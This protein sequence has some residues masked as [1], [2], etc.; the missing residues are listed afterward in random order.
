MEPGAFLLFK[1]ISVPAFAPCPVTTQPALPLGDRKCV[2]PGQAWSYKT[3]CH[4][5]PWFNTSLAQP[6][7][8]YG[9]EGHGHTGKHP[10]SVSGKR[11][12]ILN[13]IPEAYLSHMRHETEQ[14]RS[15]LPVAIT[16]SAELRAG[17]Q[18]ECRCAPKSFENAGE[19]CRLIAAK[20]SYGPPQ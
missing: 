8:R 10:S 3:V 4:L 5:Q 16:G 7:H 20:P 19:R 13:S 17:T 11:R 9:Q 14:R 1:T 18:E 15:C 2:C 12:S 6:Y